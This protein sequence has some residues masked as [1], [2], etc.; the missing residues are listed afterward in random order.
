MTIPRRRLAFVVPALALG[1]AACQG[2][3]PPA[4][5]A[6]T[7]VRVA[8][9]TS[10]PALPVVTTNGTIRTREELRLSF[11]VAGIVS[12]IAVREG[13]TVRGG[14][15]LATLELA[16]IDAQVEQARQLADKAERDRARGER[17]KADEVISQEE[18]EALRTQAEV[19]RAQLRAAEF[20][21]RY[22]AIVAT[23]DGIVLRKLVEEREFVSP[24]QAVLLIGPVAGGFV[25]RAALADRD[26]VRLRLGDPVTVTLDAWPGVALRGRVT[27]I[28]GAAEEA[29]GLFEVEVELEAAPV[30]LVSGLVARLAIEPVGAGGATLPQVPV[31]AVVEADGDRAAVFV[32]E[33]GVAQ[34]RAVRVAFV[35]PQVVAIA[36]GL[37]PGE[38]V[39]TEGAAYL[40]DGEHVAAVT[41]P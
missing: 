25:A 18:L 8:A 11:K 13:E 38:V 30:A 22:A 10:G 19:A 20:N 7:P 26:V 37:A 5:A 40:D 17:L 14:Q 29:T 39:V 1:L 12:R 2:A 34:R 32:V 23:R 41:G 15:T 35:A 24:G 21:R 27:E 31:G 33:Q 3:P 9:V 4:A 28:A 6:P 36:S 16:E